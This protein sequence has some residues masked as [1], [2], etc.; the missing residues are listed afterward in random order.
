LCRSIPVDPQSLD[1]LRSKFA[2]GRGDLL[3]G[4]GKILQPEGELLLNGQS[5]KY[6]SSD[7]DRV[8]AHLLWGR[9]LS[10]AEI[11]TGPRLGFSWERLPGGGGRHHQRAFQL[12]KATPTELRQLRGQLGRM[13]RDFYHNF[14]L[15]F[16]VDR[17]WKERWQNWNHLFPDLAFPSSEA[18]RKAVPVKTKR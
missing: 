3:I 18:M 13:Q 12:D 5:I 4:L 16:Q 9:P 15:N 1:K 14:L 7:T 8:M 11:T 2:T 17:P 10:A 6:A